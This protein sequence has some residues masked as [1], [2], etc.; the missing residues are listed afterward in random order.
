MQVVRL[1]RG[2]KIRLSDTEMEALSKFMDAGVADYAYQELTKTEEKVANY[3]ANLGENCE[4]RR[5]PRVAPEVP[6][7]SHQGPDS[8]LPE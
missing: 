1:Q 3:F 8:P 4:D 7:P 5:R 6:Q 2:W